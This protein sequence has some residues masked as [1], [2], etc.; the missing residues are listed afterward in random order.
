MKLRLQS[1][2]IRLRLKRAEVDQLART[3]RIEEHIH[4]G[5]G[6]ADV[7][8]YAIQ[9]ERDAS[10]LQASLQ[11]N[12]VLVEAPVDLIARW[13]S[14]PEIEMAAVVTIGDGRELRLL[15]EKD[16]ACLNGD[17]EQNRDTFPNPL[18]GNTC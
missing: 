10:A 13:A 7:F 5:S 9:A 6:D 15:I 2:S 16:F 4:L 17:E 14:G 1:N 12:R 8:T 3:G 18:A 11:K